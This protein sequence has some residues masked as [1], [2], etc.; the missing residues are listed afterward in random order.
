MIFDKSVYIGLNRDSKVPCLYHSGTQQKR[1]SLS[2]Y[3]AIIVGAGFAGIYQLYRLQELKLR[4]LLLEAGG[5]V[6]G[7]WHWNRYPG[8][9]S[10]VHSLTYRY[11]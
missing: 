2:N 3:D 7:T 11:S 9:S 4:V 1:M 5:N 8:A 10:D 6:G